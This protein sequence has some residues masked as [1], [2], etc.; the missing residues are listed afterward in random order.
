MSTLR[1]AAAPTSSGADRDGESV[2]ALDA[3]VAELSARAST[4]A[5][6]GPAERAALLGRVIEDT[7]A[8]SE[9]WLAAACAAK[10]YDPQSPEGG[11]ELFSGIGTFVHLARVLR[12]A[13]TDLAAGRPPRLPGP[14]RHVA[15]NRLSVRVVPASLSDRILNAGITAEVWTEPGVTEDELRTTQAPAYRD[16]EAHA[17][18]ALVLAAGNVASLGPRDALFQLFNEGRVVVMK[19]NPVNDYLV[20]HWERA[21]AALIE[22]GALAIVRG[23]AAAGAHLT[24][25]PLVDVVHV[26]GSDKTYDAIVFGPGEEGARRKAEDRP[27]LDKPV[28]AELGCVSPVVVVPGPWTRREV[29]FQ[30]RH[31]ATML[32]N[33][34]GF[35]CLTPRVLVT[36]AGWAQRAEFLE[37]LEEVLASLPARRPYYPGARERQQAFLEAHPDARLIGATTPDT[38]PWTLIAGVD[39]TDR[40]DVCLNVEAFCGLTSETALPESDPAAFL[41]AAVRLCNETLWGTLSA[42]VLVDPRTAEMPEV[43]EALERAVADLRYGAVGVNAWHALAFALGT[44]T[45]GAF[46]GHTRQDIQ[47]GTGVVGNALMIARP[48][49]TVVRGPFLAKPDPAWFATNR[50]GGTVMRKLLDWEAHPSARRVLALVV[51]ALKG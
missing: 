51:A 27:Q 49:K 26:T 29:E 38:A 32:T 41:D 23:G 46:P 34:A 7:W 47:S 19:A 6:T 15:G 21:M 25:H 37:A 18:V 5:R 9:A 11:E 2:E 39:P 30:A 8:E 20:P 33:N 45:W 12:G 24:S 48:E 22:V 17:G 42:T 4:W 31:V 35:N 28:T 16:P 40:E 43:A 44:T 1:G 50:A 13:L 36:S 10:G 14:V 3:A